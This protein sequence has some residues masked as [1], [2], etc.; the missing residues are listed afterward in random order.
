MLFWDLSLPEEQKMWHFFHCCIKMETTNSSLYEKK[1]AIVSK[2]AA[3]VRQ[4][5]QHAFVWLQ[6]LQSKTKTVCGQHFYS[7]TGVIQ[8]IK[9]TR[10]MFPGPE[11][12]IATHQL[13]RWELRQSWHS[14]WRSIWRSEVSM[15]SSTQRWQ[16]NWVV[17]TFLIWFLARFLTVLFRPK[18]S[19]RGYPQRPWQVK[20]RQIE[21]WICDF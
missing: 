21:A 14:L 3:F 2:I 5:F 13:H 16:V 17:C 11:H 20:N 8:Q 6:Q 1:A 12:V 4:I 10:A 19:R 15:N 18:W 9:Y 7:Q